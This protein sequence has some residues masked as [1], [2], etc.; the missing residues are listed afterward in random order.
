M[1]PTTRVDKVISTLRTATNGDVLVAFSTEERTIAVTFIVVSVVKCGLIG[2][3]R[4]YYG[5]PPCKGNPIEFYSRKVFDD[6]TLFRDPVFCWSL[7]TR[8]KA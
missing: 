8:I 7:F 3:L 4:G 6:V 5:P 2:E 1:T